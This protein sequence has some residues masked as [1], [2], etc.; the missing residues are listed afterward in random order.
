MGRTQT[1]EDQQDR[2]AQSGDREVRPV[3]HDGYD[4]DVEWRME[5]TRHIIRF[6]VKG[7][8]ESKPDLF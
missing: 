4:T 1:S 6:K 7:T 8:L 5:E 3:S 2:P